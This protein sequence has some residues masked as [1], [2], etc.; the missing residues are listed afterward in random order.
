MYNYIF[1]EFRTNPDGYAVRVHRTHEDDRNEHALYD[2]D[3]PT[4]EAL[5]KAYEVVLD[6]FGIGYIPCKLP[7]EV[8]LDDD[9]ELFNQYVD[10]ICDT[11]T[12]NFKPHYKLLDLSSLISMSKTRVIEPNI[13]E[14]E[15]WDNVA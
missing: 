1:Y 8:L 3:I 6:Y 15:E 13:F 2:L 14:F 12:K 10:F 7:A 11:H 9:L 4:N 5:F